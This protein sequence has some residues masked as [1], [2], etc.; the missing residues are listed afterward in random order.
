MASH[1]R[2]YHIFQPGTYDERLVCTRDL[3]EHS[4]SEV[5]EFLDRYIS[6]RNTCSEKAS[7]YAL[8]D[9]KKRINRQ[10]AKSKI[11]EAWDRL[12]GSDPDDRLANL[13][14]DEASKVSDYAPAKNDVVAFLQSLQPS[15]A[16]SS[17]HSQN[18][19]LPPLLSQKPKSK[20]RT[21]SKISRESIHYHLKGVPYQEQN[22]K[23]AYV[24][25]ITELGKE[26]GFLQCLE[27]RM[28]SSRK[29]QISRDKFDIFHTGKR[30]EKIHRSWYLNTNLSNKQKIKYLKIACEVAG[31]VFGHRDGLKIE[32]PNG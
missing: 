14:I 29:K 17:V 25:I 26:D 21:T 3:S 16:Q 11:P 32:L 10:N 4:T 31:I 22:A 13:I 27:P 23:R 12:V 2:L 30:S 18:H 7:Q 1:W 8:D 15:G 24:S 19:S 6:Y 28:C 5:A 9:L 20:K